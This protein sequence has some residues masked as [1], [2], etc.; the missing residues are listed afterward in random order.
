MVVMT[1]ALKMGWTSTM[2]AILRIGWNGD[3]KKSA[4]VAWNLGVNV[5]KKLFC[6]FLPIYGEGVGEFFS[7]ISARLKF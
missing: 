4:L 7:K 1:A 2:M 6:R 3:K 5:V